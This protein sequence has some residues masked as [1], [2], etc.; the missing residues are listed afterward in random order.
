MIWFGLGLFILSLFAS[1]LV[2][3]PLIQSSLESAR[4]R[5]EG[6]DE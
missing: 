1:A 2:L 4:R 6:Y 3:A 5:K